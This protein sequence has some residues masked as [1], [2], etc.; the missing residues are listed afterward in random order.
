MERRH[1]PTQENLL[2]VETEDVS[3]IEIKNYGL[4]HQVT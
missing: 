1:V 3:E 2:I 4:K